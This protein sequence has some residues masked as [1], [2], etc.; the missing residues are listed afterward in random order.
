MTPAPAAPRPDSYLCPTC[1]RWKG[2]H[3]KTGLL[4]RHRAA[5][6]TRYDL[7]KG[8]L[9]PLQGLTSRQ[10]DTAMPGRYTAPYQQPYLFEDPYTEP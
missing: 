1:L 4:A 10:G 5:Q 9:H 6:G 7:C 3:I 8:S 2:E